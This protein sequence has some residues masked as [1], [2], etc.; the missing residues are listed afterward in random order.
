MS[1]S[2][3]IWNCNDFM[4]VGD[5]KEIL[6]NLPDDMFI[7][8]PVVDE[9][10]VNRIYG[11]RKVRTA[12]ILTSEHEAE[13]KREVFCLNGTMDGQDLADQVHFSGRDVGVKEILYGES[14]HRVNTP[15]WICES[16]INY[17][18]S[19][20]DGKPCSMCDTDDPL[21]SCYQENENREKSK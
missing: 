3:Y 21:L 12:G 4:R 14:T 9:D 10:N 20:G 2:H 6:N 15:E 1:D 13:D 11:F 7:V 19:S 16:C 8:I 17:P 5:L 18:P